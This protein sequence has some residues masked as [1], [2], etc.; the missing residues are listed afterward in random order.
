MQSFQ[1]GSVLLISLICLL[2]LT[3][4]GVSAM[5][6][7]SLDERM[8]GNYRDRE[9]AFQSAE[10]ALVE[11]ENFIESTPFTLSDFYDGCSGDNCFTND[12]DGG[13]GGGLCFTGTFPS[14]SNPV[15]DCVLDGSRPWEDWSRW[16]TAT[17]VREATDLADISA[18]AKYIIEFRC[19]IV[20]DPGNIEPDKNELAQWAL[21]FR[22]TALS[23]GGTSDSRIMLQTTYKK[24]DY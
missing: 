1:Q 5:K 24:L 13:T 15:N 22:I 21:S 16:D 17:Q 20:R 7:T 11:A 2:L 4:A 18:H 3:L 9:M 6:L 12:C 23:S 8:S 14:S 19:F 10:A